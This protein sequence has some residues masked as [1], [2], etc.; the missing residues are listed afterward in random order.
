MSYMF[1]EASA[2]DQDIGGWETD[3]VEDMFGMFQ[4]ATNFNQNIS[5]WNVDSVINYDEFSADSG[6]AGPANATKRPIKNSTIRFP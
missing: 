6:I 5:G 2:F 4:G 1:S 3:N